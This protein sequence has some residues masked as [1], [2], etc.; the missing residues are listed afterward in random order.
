LIDRIEGDR[1]PKERAKDKVIL[2]V[3]LISGGVAVRLWSCIGKCGKHLRLNKKVKFKQN[4]L[5][6]PWSPT[7]K[8]K[9]YILVFETRVQEA[10]ALQTT[11]F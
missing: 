11:K 8:N 1:R 2:Q 3:T 9:T 7:L 10:L 4:S 6:S 5:L